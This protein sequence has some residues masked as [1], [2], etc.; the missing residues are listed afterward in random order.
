[1]FLI[2]L[3]LA[4]FYVLPLALGAPSWIPFDTTQFKRHLTIFTPAKKPVEFFWT[5]SD[6]LSTITAAVASNNSAGWLAV[7][8]SETGGMKGAD[9]ALGY[10]S[11][12]KF[13]LEDRFTTDF[14]QPVLDTH[15]NLT[16]IDSWSTTSYVAFAFSRPT[17]TESCSN[18]QDRDLYVAPNTLQNVLVAFGTTMTFAQHAPTDRGSTLVDLN[19]PSDAAAELLTNA[20]VSDLELIPF[21]VVAPPTNVGAVVTSYCYSYFEAPT[22]A[23]YHII[24]ENPIIQDPRV[25]H[26][27]IYKCDRSLSQMFS[28]SKVM[29]GVTNPCF[30][31]LV[32]WAPGIGN[33][34]YPEEYAKP[35]GQGDL[36]AKYLLLEVHYNQVEPTRFTDPGSGYQLMLSRKLRKNDLGI[37]AIGMLPELIDIIPAGVISTKTY[38]FPEEC[39]TLLTQNM[40]VNGV[41]L[42]M[43]KR[44]YAAEATI[45]RQGTNQTKGL[46]KLNYFD[47]NSQGSVRVPPTTI[48]PGD[49]LRMTC[50]WDSRSYEKGTSGGYGSDNEMCFGFVEYYPLQALRMGWRLQTPPYMAYCPRGSGS[51]YV[52]AKEPMTPVSD[53][54]WCSVIP[55]SAYFP[56]K[57]IGLVYACVTIFAAIVA[58][59]NFT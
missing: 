19:S 28:S 46:A 49:R 57:K 41:Y 44:G 12:S 39:S 50:I 18:N 33:R 53:P 54:N 9:I 37:L 48:V 26:L 17:K 5:L 6:D 58:F 35:V 51:N 55:S 30:N 40:T 31:F 52:A 24:Q 8:F 20:P 13:V 45:I 56:T 14:A 27:V 43:H 16:L 2:T 25:H 32:E 42:H 29:C 7:G 34:T 38:E 36:S 3:A 21:N 59:S 22:D 15:Q 10:A 1:M 23:K 47:F 11:G 4:F